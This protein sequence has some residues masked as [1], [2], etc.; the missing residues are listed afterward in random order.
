MALSQSP[1]HKFFLNTGRLRL[2]NE[3]AIGDST[4]SPESN[5]FYLVFSVCVSVPQIVTQPKSCLSVE[6]GGRGNILMI[7]ATGVG[8]QYQWCKRVASM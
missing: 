4:N 2:S 1:T 8:L 7:Q 3:A 6:Q 5:C